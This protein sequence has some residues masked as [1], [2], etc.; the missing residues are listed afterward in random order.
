MAVPVKADLTT[1][2]STKAFPLG[3][4]ATN[5]STMSTKHYMYVRADDIISVNWCCKLDLAAAGSGLA[6]DA[7]FL[8]TPTTNVNEIVEGVAET[9]FTA[10]DY[11]FIIIRGHTTVRCAAGV[12]AGEQ[13][14]TTAND[15]EIDTIIVVTTTNPT[16]TELDAQHTANVGLILIA[17]TAVV[18]S[19]C[20]VLIR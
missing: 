15:G 8:M 4:I 20:E 10:G 12:A 6:A 9:A 16:K 2:G 1:V 3:T 17:L 5:L 13:V 7:P 11:G 19:K 18:S 14:V